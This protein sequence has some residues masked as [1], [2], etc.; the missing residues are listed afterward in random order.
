MEF[1]EALDAV[2]K[3]LKLL[4]VSVIAHPPRQ[5]PTSQSVFFGAIQKKRVTQDGGNEIRITLIATTSSQTDGKFDELEEITDRIDAVVDLND[6]DGLDVTMLDGDE[7]SM[8]EIEVAGV[9]Y[10]G[11]RCELTVHY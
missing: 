6:I 2:E 1:R 10:F 3:R 9:S 5:L 8:G 7:W 4:R 11:A